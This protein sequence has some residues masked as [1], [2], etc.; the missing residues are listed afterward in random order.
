MTLPKW[1]GKKDDVKPEQGAAG[2]TTVECLDCGHRGGM[3]EFL[4][5][6]PEDTTCP[7]CGGDECVY[8]L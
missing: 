7:E 5:T 2:V 6:N 8:E 1:A 3:A 4:K